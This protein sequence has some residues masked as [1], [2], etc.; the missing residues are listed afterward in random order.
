MH[1]HCGTNK[2][3]PRCTFTDPCNLTVINI[4]QTSKPFSVLKVEKDKTVEL[5]NEIAANMDTQS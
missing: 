5:Q 4:E 1:C 2:R 3:A